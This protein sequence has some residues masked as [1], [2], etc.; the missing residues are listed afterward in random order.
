M[1]IDLKVKEIRIETKDAVSIIFE[2]PGGGGLNYLSGQYLTLIIKLED[3]EV[4]R[5]Y[6]I[7]TSPFVD[8]DIAVTVKR[9]A[10]GLVSNWLPDNIQAGNVIR[11]MAPMGQFTLDFDTRL[12]R[13]IVMFAGG[14]GITPMISIIKSLLES[15]PESTCSLIYC[16][17][18]IES[19]IFKNE[20]DYLGR[21]AKGKLNIHYVLDRHN[22]DWSGHSGRLSSE[23]LAAIF[24]SVPH[25]DPDNSQYLICGPAGMMEMVETWLHNQQISRD[26]IML[27]NFFAPPKDDGAFHAAGLQPSGVSVPVS[28]RYENEIHEINVPPGKSILHAALD[29]GID[30]PYSCQSGICTSCRSKCVKGSVKMELDQG[31]SEEE[32]K[33]G[34]VLICVGYPA[35]DDVALEID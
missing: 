2:N 27:E 15:E 28:I 16:N 10:S 35:T 6:S 31:L 9:V 24:R 19:V 26:K 30:L 25:R 20:L 7:C 29:L 4:R 18:D 3:K 23:L 21:Q 12:K 17:Q 8:I 14:S 32:K 11:V 33:E 13:H 1:Y 34:Y 22:D 5:A